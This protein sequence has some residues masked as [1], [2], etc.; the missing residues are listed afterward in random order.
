VERNQATEHT[1]SKH[2][3]P[4]SGQGQPHAAEGS[5]AGVVVIGH[6]A[7]D[8]VLRVD[9]LPEAGGSGAVLERIERLGGKGANIA[10]G[11]RQLNP[12]VAVRLVAALGADAAGDAA[13]Q[14]AIEA[15]L[16]VA[17]VARRGRTALL[18]DL[19]TAPGE[20]RL[21]EDATD[22]SFVTVDDIAGAAEA[23]RGA[24][25]VV[26][27]LQQP[28]D[29]LV[30]AARIAHDGGAR[31]LIDGAIDG[32][33][34]DTL[35]SL[36]T[37]VRADAH[38]ASLL[39]GVE[40]ERREDA[41]RAAADLLDRGPSLVALAVPEEGDL[42]AW[43][44]GSRLYPHGDE[45]VADPTGGGDAFV[46]GL[47]T[48]ML[49]GDRPAQAGELASRAAGSTVQRL[50]GHPELAHLREGAQPTGGA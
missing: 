15:G 4:G 3:E 17:H 23:L 28:G 1:D 31:I 48:G 18:V 2:P 41:E 44:G 38:E 19:V 39:S 50:G 5:P 7:R 43:H 35:L 21:L 6:A 24:D 9:G 29:V 27:Q 30:E 8:L 26:L 37:A 36:A 11:I 33:A 16:D 14:E 22:E 10:V 20:R 13:R 42:V 47:V 40:I 12:D 46:A 45:P 25:I 32:D 34:R 49:R